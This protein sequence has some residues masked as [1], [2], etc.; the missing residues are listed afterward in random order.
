MAM[1]EGGDGAP[2]PYPERDYLTPPATL[3]AGR[4]ALAGAGA[5]LAGAGLAWGLKG[6]TR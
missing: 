3:S 4:V 1:R 5:L 6:R 2:H